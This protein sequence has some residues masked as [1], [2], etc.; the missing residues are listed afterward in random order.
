MKKFKPISFKPVKKEKM[1]TSI[2][3]DSDMFETLDKLSS[4]NN[5]SRNEFIVQCI[6]FALDNMK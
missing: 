2:R 1:I 3:L 5:L 6:K 4:E